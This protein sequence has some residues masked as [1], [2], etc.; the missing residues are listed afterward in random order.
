MSFLDDVNKVASKIARE[1]IAEQVLRTSPILDFI[2]R[3]E[4]E[5]VYRRAQR[6][7]YVYPYRERMTR[8]PEEK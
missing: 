5:S 1:A 8:I 2:T 3:N 4:L 6:Y 7:G